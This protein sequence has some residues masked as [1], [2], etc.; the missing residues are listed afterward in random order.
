M[1]AWL[2]VTVWR[3][4]NPLRKEPSGWPALRQ[5]GAGHTGRRTTLV[6]LGGVPHC[7]QPFTPLPQG[8]E[9]GLPIVNMMENWDFLQIQVRSAV[10]CSAT[11]RLC[12]LCTLGWWVGGVAS[13]RAIM[14]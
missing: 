12:M 11:C 1:L 2:G 3:V 10:Q 13:P 8:L 5:Q 14:S 9:K 6:P 4:S 7:A